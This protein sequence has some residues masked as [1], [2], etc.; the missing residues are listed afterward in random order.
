M[1]GL[2]YFLIAQKVK[3]LW[4]EKTGKAMASYGTSRWWSKWD[5]VAQVF[6]YFGDIE[7]FLTQNTD[8][9]PATRAKLLPFFSDPNKNA[10]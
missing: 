3:L 2:A 10:N 1:V 4:K 5:L 9:S 6:K 7:P 8:F